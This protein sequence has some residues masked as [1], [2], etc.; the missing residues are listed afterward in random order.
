MRRIRARKARLLPCEK[1]QNRGARGPARRCGRS[2]R[3]EGEEIAAELGV[4]KW[5]EDPFECLHDPEIDA[6][7][8]V[9]PTS[10][11]AEVIKQ[12]A[13]CG[14]QIFVEK[15]LTLNL[16]ESIEVISKVKETGVIC[17]VGF[18][19]R[20]D[21]A[22]ADAKRRIDAGEIGKPIYYKGF[23]RDFGSPPAEF[24]KK[25]AVFSS[26]VR[27]TIMISRVI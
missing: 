21:P 15:P 6:V 27:F 24:I 7:V 8:I 10:T 23:T 22:Y 18:M 9:T 19:R 20:F 26:I 11:H 13:E 3:G 14:K 12:A 25:A 17:Q 1:P 4:E 5:F 2:G 16:E